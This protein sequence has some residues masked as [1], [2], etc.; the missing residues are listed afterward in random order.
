MGKML[1]AN[2]ALIMTGSLLIGSFSWASDAAENAD[3]EA[4]VN[5]TIAPL[6]AEHRIP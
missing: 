5:D 6:M 2:S 4:L 1:A 3:I